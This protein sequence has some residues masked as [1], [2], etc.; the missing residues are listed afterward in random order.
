MSAETK[1][2]AKD[3][4]EVATELFAR[5]GFH[6][7]SVRD[8]CSELQVNCSTISYYFGGKS[9]LYMSVLKAQ[10]EAYEDSLNE[11]ITRNPDP[12]EEFLALCDCIQQIH[13]R[14]PH[15]AVI[16]CRES[17]NPSPE[18]CKALYEHEAK[19]GG[20]HLLNLIR[21]GQT[22]GTLNPEINPVYLSRIMSMIFN[23]QTVAR[24]MSDVL[25]SEMDFSDAEY[26]ATVKA[27][28]LAGVMN[29]SG[30]KTTHGEASS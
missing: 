12:K 20:G 15:L 17:C 27:I 29:Y 28:L 6:G 7:V 4:L 14:C 13:I 18:W 5:R 2:R 9:K 19:Y 24:T 26:Y 25:H 30:Q 11:N 23:G 3:L 22:Q 16:A 10:F 8:I 1:D 21:R